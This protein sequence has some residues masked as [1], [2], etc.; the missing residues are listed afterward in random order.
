MLCNKQVHGSFILVLILNDIGVIA[1]DYFHGCL[2]QWE[3][4]ALI[5]QWLSSTDCS[6]VEQLLQGLPAVQD[7]S[8]KRQCCF[9]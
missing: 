5:A 9:G 3:R 1:K 7:G 6:V 2:V 4:L 8:S